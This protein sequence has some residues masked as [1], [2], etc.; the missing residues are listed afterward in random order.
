MSQDSNTTIVR[1]E[2]ILKAQ[3]TAFD[4]ERHR[5]LDDR[6]SD[7]DKIKAMMIKYGD[8][9]SD[10]INA[11]FGRRARAET[12]LSEVGFLI[13]DALHNRKNLPH[14]MSAKPRSVGM[15]LLPAK[16]YIR[17][18]P[19]GVVGVIAP[20]N[21]PLQLSV[22]PLIAALS[23]GCR[24][25]IKPSELSPRTSQ[26]L[27]EALADYFPD[28]HVAVINGGPEVSTAFSGLPFDHLF[29]TGSPTIGRKV[30]EA[31][32]K[33]LTPLTLELGGKS[34]AVIAP[35][36]D[37]EEAAKTISWGKFF[38]GGQTCVGVD[39][40]LTP[41]G[42]EHR[43]A[44]AV[45]EAFQSQWPDVANNDDFTTMLSEQHAERQRELIEDAKKAGADIRQIELTGEA[46]EGLNLIP[47]TIV[48]NPPDGTRVLKEE[49]FGPILVIRGHDGMSDAARIVNEGERPLAL[50]VYAKSRQTARRFLSRTMSGGATVNMPLIHYS[51]LNLPFGG[52][53]QSG[54]GAYHG[55]EGFLTFTHQ[56]SVIE[57]GTWHPTRLII[58][59]YG[60]AYE[61]FKKRQVK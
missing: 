1:A 46:P 52:V 35:D 32:A 58:P 24:V 6:K 51:A 29:F 12:Q 27:A 45:L 44:D 4:Q 8:Q 49:I 19:K 11:D 31:A 7:L 14:W 43:L 17:R 30:A 36:F 53:G 2:E 10:A 26:L 28:D 56:R 42:S 39:Y 18:E 60:K 55:E 5:S 47:P 16:G 50:Y 9:F 25:M 48:I 15:N 21:Y 23:A 20:W 41:Q 61:F 37:I 33:N 59:P 38:N 54:Q 3:K 34:P 57:T 22:S 13:G 40:V